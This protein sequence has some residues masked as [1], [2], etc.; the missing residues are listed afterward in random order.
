MDRKTEFLREK[1]RLERVQD[2]DKKF[3]LTMVDAFGFNSLKKVRDTKYMPFLSQLLKR[4]NVTSYNVGV[5]TTTPYVQASVFYGVNDMIPGFRYFDK[6][7]KK[8]IVAGSPLGAFHVEKK[9]QERGKGILV[10]GS[11]LG[12]IFAGGAKRTLFTFP[13]MHAKSR[14]TNVRDV[15]SVLAVNPFSFFRVGYYAVNE[16]F[17]EVYE[18]VYDLLKKKKGEFVNF[19]FFYPFFPFFRLGINSFTR[20]VLTEA[21]ILEMKR[22]VPRIAVNFHG[23]DWV[24]HYRGPKSKSA[25]LV[26]KEIDKKLKWLYKTAKKE[27]YDFYIYSDHD[28]VPSVPFDKLYNQ[29]LS[30]FITNVKEHRRSIRDKDW[31]YIAYKLKYMHENL[32]IPLKAVNSFLLQLFKVKKKHKVKKVSVHNSSSLAHVYFNEHE[33]RLNLE[34]V[35]KHYPGLIDKLVNHDGVG[36][37]LGKDE[38]GF[39]VLSKH[40]KVLDKYGGEKMLLKSIRKFV[41]MEHFGDLCVVGDI[42]GDK[43]V[44]FEDF[45]LG[46]HDSFGLEQEKGIF[47]SKEKHDLTNSEDASVLYSILKKYI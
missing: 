29:S 1:L 35:E 34:D 23:Y 37:V 4:Y 10:N 9:L 43:M 7:Y 13:G 20:E 25:K 24:S 30:E 45:H 27:G 2:S 16:F 46:S 14:I 40:K 22:K 28:I 5:P 11:S 44:S 31:D 36:V 6:N 38:K 41:D 15:L 17:V 33:G 18:N 42:K 12:N 19:S 32:S 21:A 26:L 8:R 39:Q 47:I 3:I